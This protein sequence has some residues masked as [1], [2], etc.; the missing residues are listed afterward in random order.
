MRHS[1]K[2]TTLLTATAVT[3]LLAAPA[4]FAQG[5]ETGSLPAGPQQ[6]EPPQQQ[7]NAS[8]DELGEVTVTATRHTDTVNRVPLSITALT[9]KSLETQSIDTVQD[10]TRSVPGLTLRYT[11][12][13]ALNPEIRGVISTDGSPTT[14]VYLDD[15]ALQKRAGGGLTVGNGTPFPPLF[16][17]ER[18]E[19][20]RGPQGTLF[21]GSS[22]GGTIRFITPSPS[23]TDFSVYTKAEAGVMYGGTPSYEGGFAVGGPIVDNQLGF[24]VSVYDRHIGGDLDHINQYTA[25]HTFENSNYDDTRLVRGA[26]AWEAAD[27]VKITAAAFWSKDELNDASPFWV[28]QPAVT[29]PTR[30]YSATSAT[31][32]SAPTASTVYTYP[33]HTYGPYNFYGPGT[34]GENGLSPADSTLFTPSLTADV[35]LNKLQVKNILS[36][37]YDNSEGQQNEAASPDIAALQAGVPYIAGLPNFAALFPYQNKRRGLSEELRLSTDWE[38]PVSIVG[39]VYYAEYH[40]H[41]VSEVVEDL[42]A[43][44]EVLMGLPA[45]VKYGATLLPGGVASSRD[46]TIDEREL[47]AYAQANWKIISNVTLTVG[48]RVSGER[49]HYYQINNG[50][51]SGYDI[52]KPPTLTNGGIVNGVE[53][54]TP[55]TPKFGLEYQFTPDDMVYAS[56]AKGFREGGVNTQLPASCAAGA[57]AAGFADGAPTTYSP[58]TLWSYET[59]AKLRLFDN[60]MQLNTSVFYIDWSNIQFKASLP[61][62]AIP[63]VTNAASAVSK[64]FDVQGTIRV[65]GGLTTDFS[66][67]YTDAYYSAQVDSP[68]TK[69]VLINDGNTLPTPNWTMNLGGQYTLDLSRYSLYLRGDYEWK[70]DYLN[71]TGPGTTS[72]NPDTY[73]I[74]TTRFVNARLG[75]MFGGWD[76]SMFAKNLTNSQDVLGYLGINLGRY[77]C[78]AATGAACTTYADY[79]PAIRAFTYRPREIGLTATYRF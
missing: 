78:S 16:D 68:G 17:L 77:G 26:L 24:R 50:P 64:G 52:A 39:G 42:N 10:I 35:N 12:N 28:D 51:V 49:L 73:H 18:I 22:E 8:H 66:A 11:D 56:A 21:G 27:A 75:A 30:Y 47:A 71:G 1:W 4:A 37:V 60:R 23:L 43:A 67:A 14:G 20:L 63:F 55:S 54:S 15:T 72:Y 33:S 44:T 2:T 74:P 69:N 70:N 7:A 57:A 6:A 9:E 31:P 59:G 61:G 29:T 79:N 48:E 76:V 40:T 38:G 32:T 58:D 62:C 5:S 34:A 13:N 45:Q 36:Y 19:V 41:S 46:Q 53:K 25:Q 3:R 65:I